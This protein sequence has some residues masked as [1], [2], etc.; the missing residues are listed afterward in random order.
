MHVA[1]V[2]RRDAVVGAHRAFHRVQPPVLVGLVGRL[3]HVELGP[4]ALGAGAVARPALHRAAQ[5]RTAVDIVV[6]GP[7][8]VAARHTVEHVAGDRFAGALAA[9]DTVLERGR[10]RETGAGVGLVLVLGPAR[11][12]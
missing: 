6:L 5:R 2:L 11:T 12:R 3:G 8:V 10:P 7:L 1:H 4:Q 9:G